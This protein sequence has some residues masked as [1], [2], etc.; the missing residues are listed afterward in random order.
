MIFLIAFGCMT[1]N[2][3][4]TWS[5][6]VYGLFTTQ[7]ETV[8]DAQLELLNVEGESLTVAETPYVENKSYQEFVLETEYLS[9]EIQLKLSG[10]EMYPTQYYGTTPQNSSIWFNGSLYAYGILWT[11][12]FFQ[13]LGYSIDSP[14]NGTSVQLIGRPSIP[15]D[16]KNVELT[17]DHENGSTLIVDRFRYDETGFLLAIPDENETESIDIFI[18]TDIPP[19]SLI[20]TATHL[21]GRH[22]EIPY[23]ADGGTIINAAHLLFSPLE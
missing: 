18:C 10:A 5:G 8:S 20:L 11:E 17:V 6:N 4:V 2:Q 13:S 7:L 21:D 15:E 22:M 12:S 23:H 3:D 14:S 1:Q 16:W 9:K 19:G